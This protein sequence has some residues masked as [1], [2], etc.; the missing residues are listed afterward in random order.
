MAKRE[1]AALEAKRL[2]DLLNAPHLWA[3]N[4]E[5]LTEEAFLQ[6]Q[7]AHTLI[8]EWIRDFGK[9][10]EYRYDA[11]ILNKHNWQEVIDDVNEVRARHGQPPIRSREW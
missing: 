5:A 7:E 2:S 4:A 9:S 1:I 10:R 8:A 3:G 6:V 11:W